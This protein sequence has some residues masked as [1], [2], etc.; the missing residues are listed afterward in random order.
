MFAFARG[1]CCVLAGAAALV[2]CCSST[3]HARRGFFLIT[4]GDAIKHVGD[5]VPEMRPQVQAATGQTDD[6]QVGLLH[7]RFG[8]FWVDVWTWG[9]EYVLYNG[10]DDVWQLDPEE[11]ASLTGKTVAQ[12]QKPLWYTVPPGLVAAIVLGGCWAVAAGRQR[13]LA[14][15]RRDELQQ[16]ADDPRYQRALASLREHYRQRDEQ[17]AQP[18]FQSDPARQAQA[19]QAAFDRAVQT[20]ADQGVAREDAERRLWLL[21]SAEQAAS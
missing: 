15:A 13:K 12:L 20:L 17:A 8:V 5:V 1:Q 7:Q 2:I 21:L 6:V 18:D 11:A 19:D 3:A 10:G 16:T 4:H 9:G 14:A